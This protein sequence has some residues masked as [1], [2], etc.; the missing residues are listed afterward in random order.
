MLL[1]QA[2]DLDEA[3]DFRALELLADKSGGN[4]H[5]VENVAD[6]VKHTRG[7]QPCRLAGSGQQ[8]LVQFVQ[9]RSGA[10]L[11]GNVLEDAAH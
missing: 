11:F 8:L 6:V 5:A 10:L 4:V 1:E 9:F 3:G 7:D 2:A